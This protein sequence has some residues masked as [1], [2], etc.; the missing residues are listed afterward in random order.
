MNKHATNNRLPYLPCGNE[1]K[2][3]EIYIFV[4]PLSPECW[5][6]EPII[7]KLQLEYGQH[8]KMKYVLSGRLATLNVRKHRL[9]KLAQQWERT[10]SRYGMSC[11]GTIWLENLISTPFAASI[12]IKAAEL[13]GRRCSTRF[14]RKL[15]ETLFLEKQ[16][17][18]DHNV[19]IECAKAVGLDVD[20]FIK[21]I[22]SD[23]AV[24]AFQS[25]LKITAEM[26]VYEIPTIVF[27]NEHIEEEGIKVSGCYPFSV[28]RDLL[29]HMLG[30]IPECSPLPTLTEF[31][32]CFNFVA[33]AEVAT[34][35]N[36]STKETERELKKLQL[37]RIVEQIPVKYGTFWRY[38][39]QS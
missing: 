31:M 33:T 15:Q 20:E 8:F 17:I 6:L 39:S 1:Q 27:F 26:N 21:D 9:G 5:A 4:D 11:D 22:Y 7:K 37:N 34:V 30:H 23:S 36:L 25:D 10:A 14:F 3:I 38:I 24:K 18:C 28:Y 19:L 35:Y 16:N 29:G 32:R 2:P 12:A 13:Q